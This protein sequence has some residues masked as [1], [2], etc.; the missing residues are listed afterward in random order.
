MGHDF[1]LFWW[2]R[3]QVLHYYGVLDMW[4]LDPFIHY[5]IQRI[6]SVGLSRV[7][8]VPYNSCEGLQF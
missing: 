4:N 7:T 5:T 6:R 3:I 1:D 8:R 2:V